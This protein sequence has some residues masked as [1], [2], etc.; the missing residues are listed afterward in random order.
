MNV[1]NRD[2]RRY[3]HFMYQYDEKR[4]RQKKKEEKSIHANSQSRLSLVVLLIITCFIRKDDSLIV[5]QK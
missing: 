5:R 4:V 3:K 2:K 1:L